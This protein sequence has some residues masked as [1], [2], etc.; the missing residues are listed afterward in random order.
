MISNPMSVPEALERGRT[1]PWALVRRM[2]SVT[3]GP[4]P[5]EIPLEDLLEA[6]FFSPD[7]EIRIF[8]GED[9]E[10]RGVRLTEKEGETR[11]LRTY[12]VANPALGKT[13]TVCCH[14]QPDDDGQCSLVAPRLA[15]WKG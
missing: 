10:L 13:I 9:E 12:V 5:A 1:L 11:I 2:S 14:V 4:V 8:R 3:L 7:E 15:G 6:H